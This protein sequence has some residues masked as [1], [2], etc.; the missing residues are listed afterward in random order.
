LVVVTADR[1]KPELLA[2]L[3]VLQG[4]TWNP[5]AVVGSQ[6]YLRNA[7]EMARVDLQIDNDSL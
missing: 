3:P 6:I 4:T 5:L 1:S 2:R 7:Q